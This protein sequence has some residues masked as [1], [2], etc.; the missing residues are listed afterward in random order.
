MKRTD[1]F[2]EYRSDLTPFSEMCINC[3]Y[4]VQHYVHYRK[5]IYVAIDDGHC[6]KGRLKRCHCYEY[7]VDF[8]NKF[9]DEP[10]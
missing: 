6:R 5:D 2:R 10:V 1:K 3:L 9:Y 8:V 4:F 7:C